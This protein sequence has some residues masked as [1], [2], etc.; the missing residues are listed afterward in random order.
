MT[1]MN[2]P[3]NSITDGMRALLDDEL[4]EPG[5]LYLTPSG[6]L[7]LMSV[8]GHRGWVMPFGVG[9]VFRPTVLTSKPE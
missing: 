1:P 8:E 6:K 2:L 5:D 7:V 3:K 9:K 4:I